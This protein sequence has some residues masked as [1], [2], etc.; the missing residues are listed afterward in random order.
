MDVGRDSS[1]RLGSPFSFSHWPALKKY[2]Q[3]NGRPL[4]RAKF[5]FV[6]DFDLLIDHF[7]AKPIER[8]MDPVM[9]FAV[10]DEGILETSL[11]QSSRRM[12]KRS[13]T[14]AIASRE[15]AAHLVMS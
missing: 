15:R 7:N 13:S 12:R 4:W 11:A 5:L 6:Y 2:R 3:L 8:H 14:P 1:R 10:N 9:L